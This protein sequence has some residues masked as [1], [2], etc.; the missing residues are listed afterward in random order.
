MNCAYCNQPLVCDSCKAEYNPPSPEAYEALSEGEEA[1]LC[2]AC[3][4]ILVCH[5]CKTPY[6]GSFEEE[7]HQGEAS[8]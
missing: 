3:E 5:W 2:P 8:A 6:D 1:I 4:Q 7:D